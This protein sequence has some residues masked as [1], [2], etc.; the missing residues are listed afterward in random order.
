MTTQMDVT[1]K[2]APVRVTIDPMTAYVV[3][4]VGE[5]S[6]GLPAGDARIMSKQIDAACAIIEAEGKV[7]K[8]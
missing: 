4:V 2:P 8:Q 1:A 3:I 5:F 6:F 7:P